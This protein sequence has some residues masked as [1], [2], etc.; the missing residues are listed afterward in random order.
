MQVL[1]NLRSKYMTIE[2]DRQEKPNDRRILTDEELAAIEQIDI[3]VPGN[4]GPARRGPLK[5]SAA[6]VAQNWVGG[7]Y[8]ANRKN[9]HTAQARRQIDEHRRDAGKEEY[10]AARRGEYAGE[11]MHT[12]H[13]RVRPYGVP[14]SAEK[15]Q[16]RRDQQLASKKLA[17]AGRSPER[18]LA[19]KAADAARK[20]AK[21]AQKRS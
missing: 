6:E 19:D 4:N 3:L 10:N 13:R 5:L 1:V 18:I 9:G 8:E 14:A 16:T 11:I 15:T 17:M 7:D 12:E 21:R 2:N 20:K